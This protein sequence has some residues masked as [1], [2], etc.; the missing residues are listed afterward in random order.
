MKNKL[1]RLLLIQP[2][3]FEKYHFWINVYIHISQENKILPRLVSEDEF[4]KLE[5]PKNNAA[6]VGVVDRGHNLAEQGAGS[7]FPQPPAR[8]HVGMEIAVARR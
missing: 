1:S 6:A 7:G 5:I 3:M 2:K 8:T 4:S